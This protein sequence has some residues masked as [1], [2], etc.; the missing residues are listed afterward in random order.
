MRRVGAIIAGLLALLI[1]AAPALA[2]AQLIGMMPAV[3]STVI[4]APDH[5]VL[6]FGET[7]QP[8]GSSVVVLDPSGA[9]VQT[10]ELLVKGPTI[11]VGLERISQPGTYRVEYRV[12]ST[13][14]HVVTDARSFVFAPASGSPAPAPVGRAT[15]DVDLDPPPSG[16]WLAFAT[17]ALLLGAVAVTVLV[18]RRRN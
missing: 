5:V 10:D 18:I 16:G 11:T 6:R 9:E 7:M 8:L 17:A 14:G 12:L 3:G 13:D 15:R 4:T 1:P 2:H